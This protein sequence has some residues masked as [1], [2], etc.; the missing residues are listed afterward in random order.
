[1]DNVQDWRPIREF[2]LETITTE[3]H[4]FLAQDK[5]F[6]PLGDELWENAD[7]LGRWGKGSHNVKVL[8]SSPRLEN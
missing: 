3:G 5:S 1:M 4:D 6:G 2:D 8:C 7:G